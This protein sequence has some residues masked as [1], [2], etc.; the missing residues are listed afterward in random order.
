VSGTALTLAGTYPKASYM[1]TLVNAIV[2]K[3][4]T[5]YIPLDMRL[6]EST[7]KGM[8][9]GYTDKSNYVVMVV[10]PT[11]PNGDVDYK[12]QATKIPLFKFLCDP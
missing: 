11:M 9:V 1:V 10:S 12:F 4:K 6:A 5:I 3:G 2:V 7:N 8:G